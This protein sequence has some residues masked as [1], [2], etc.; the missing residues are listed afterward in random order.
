VLCVGQKRTVIFVTFFHLYVHYFVINFWNHPKGGKGWC[1]LH[2][3]SRNLTSRNTLAKGRHLANLANRTHFCN[4]C[5][6]NRRPEHSQA[7]FG[8]VPTLEPPVGT[9]QGSV[10]THRG[11]FYTKRKMGD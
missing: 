10:S 5:F 7:I 11:R 3:R 9:S 1:T 8:G 6:Q 2:A 4:Q